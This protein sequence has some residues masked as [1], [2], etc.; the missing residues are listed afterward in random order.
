MKLLKAVIRLFWYVGHVTLLSGWKS[1][2]A[3][4]WEEAEANGKG[5][6][7]DCKSERSHQQI[8]GTDAQKSDI[9]LTKGGQLSH[10]LG[11]P[12]NQP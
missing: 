10:R 4:S 1:L 6:A 8:R 3:P 5:V 7:G 11:K 12:E 2:S 9:R